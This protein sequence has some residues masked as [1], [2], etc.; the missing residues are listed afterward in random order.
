MING[1]TERMGQLA[2]SGEAFRWLG[3][4]FTIAYHRVDISAVKW[5][6]AF[7]GYLI[8]SKRKQEVS[9]G[10]FYCFHGPMPQT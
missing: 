8:G 2:G 1:H 10:L 7:S 5:E 9:C 3:S 6:G 4:T